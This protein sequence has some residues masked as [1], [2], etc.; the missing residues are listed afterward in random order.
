[1]NWANRE[2]EQEGAAEEEIQDHTQGEG[3]RE[4]ENQRGQEIGDQQKA[5]S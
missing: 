3:A 2:Q 5:Q 1:M 4:E